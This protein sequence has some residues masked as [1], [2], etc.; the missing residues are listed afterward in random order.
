[1]ALI[2][3]LVREHI[4]K[5]EL[6]F[7]QSSLGYFYKELTIGFMRLNKSALEDYY[8]LLLSDDFDI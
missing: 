2:T 7:S 1:M 3:E 6:V 8:I 5:M 4:D